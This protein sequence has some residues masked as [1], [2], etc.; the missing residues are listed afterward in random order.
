MHSILRWAVVLLHLARTGKSTAGWFQRT[1]WAAPDKKLGL[2]TLICT[3]LQLV[4]GLVVYG[5]LSPS[6]QSAMANPPAAMAD[7][8]LR[9]WFVEH[10]F[11]MILAIVAAHVGHAMSKRGKTD[12]T[13][14]RAA[15]LGSLV[16]L[17]LIFV[18][19]PW[20]WRAG[21]GRPLLPF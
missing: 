8:V 20:P 18:G 1:P 11:I 7:P 10:G 14:H 17:V 3:D 16:T 5:A 13:Q 12:L 9:F 2:V 21:V 4:V 15:A 19:M 6:V